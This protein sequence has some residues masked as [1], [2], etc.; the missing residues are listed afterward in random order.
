MT[1]SG[2]GSSQIANE[3]N[4]RELGF[5]PVSSYAGFHSRKIQEAKHILIP[6]MQ[7]RKR[8]FIRHQTFTHCF[9]TQVPN[10]PIYEWHL[11]VWQDMHDGCKTNGV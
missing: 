7:P 8:K 3:A 5:D 6:G 11:A 9:S 1:R 4:H 2:F 10:S